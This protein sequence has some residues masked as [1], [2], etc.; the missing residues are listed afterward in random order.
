M[1]DHI[2]HTLHATQ[3]WGIYHW[4]CVNYVLT[5][6]HI[7]KITV[8]LVKPNLYCMPADRYVPPSNP[9]GQVG[10]KLMNNPHISFT[11]NLSTMFFSFAIRTVSTLKDN[12]GL[13]P[14][15]ITRDL[16][17]YLHLCNTILRCQ[18]S[19]CSEETVSDWFLITYLKQNWVENTNPI[20]Q[21]DTVD[22][23]RT[24]TPIESMV[25]QHP[26]WTQYRSQYSARTLTDFI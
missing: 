7:F 20:D 8:Y 10:K 4:W 26:H 11:I 9:V 13:Q 24:C 16:S 23:I 12:L 1:S 6:V 14:W 21:T 22:E 5:K 25:H 17:M 15:N 18:V 2:K 3:P 19:M